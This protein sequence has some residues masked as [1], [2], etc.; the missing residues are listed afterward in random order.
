MVKVLVVAGGLSAGPA[1]PPIL[2]P[3]AADI[4][5]VMLSKFQMQPVC[6]GGNGR[7]PTAAIYNRYKL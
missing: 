4:V 7:I 1:A 2:S 6:T 5:G 3:G